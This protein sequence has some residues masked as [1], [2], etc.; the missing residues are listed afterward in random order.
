[1]SRILHIETATQ[2]CSVSLSENGKLLAFKEQTGNYTHAENLTVFIQQTL[3]EANFNFNQLDAISVSK[4]PGSYTGLRI[5]VS[6]AKG[7]CFA[8]E[9]PLIAVDTLKSMTKGV[10]LNQIEADFFCPMIDARRMEVYAEIVDK[11]LNVVRSVNAD[12]VDE[13]TYSEFL[14]ENSVCFFGNGMIKCKEILSTFNTSIFVEGIEP[15]AKYMVEMA[16]EKFLK[17]EFEDVAYFEP[18][19]LKDFIAGKPKKLL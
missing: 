1:L 12:I 13:N 16:T 3:E 5:G 6:T 2:N 18:H 11:K 4:G 9:I 19:Y 10:L 14:R 17:K 15:S 8:L 7:I